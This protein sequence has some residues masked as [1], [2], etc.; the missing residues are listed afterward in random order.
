MVEREAVPGE[1]DEIGTEGPS[2][3]RVGG[4][5]RGNNPL[6]RELDVAARS[7]IGEDEDAPSLTYRRATPHRYC[8]SGV[9]ER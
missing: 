7:P 4:R 2:L 1:L 6:S 3:F 5:E 8:F 9:C